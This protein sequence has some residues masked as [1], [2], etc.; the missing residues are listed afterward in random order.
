MVAGSNT[1]INQKTWVSCSGSAPQHAQLMLQDMK[2]FTYVQPVQVYHPLLCSP[3]ALHLWSNWV[4]VFL[5][6]VETRRKAT[7][8]LSKKENKNMKTKVIGGKCQ[9]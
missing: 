6:R 1:N 4:P 5:E 8:K 2:G 3:I 7:N 9:N